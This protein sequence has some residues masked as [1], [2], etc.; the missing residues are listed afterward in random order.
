MRLG[1]GLSSLGGVRAFLRQACSEALSPEQTAD[2]ELLGTEL[3]ANAMRHGAAPIWIEVNRA[4]CTVRIAVCD[5]GSGRPRPSE[6]DC[7]DESGRGLAL[8]RPSPTNGD[9]HSSIAAKR[10]GSRSSPQPESAR[11]PRSSGHPGHRSTRARCRQRWPPR[12]RRRAGARCPVGRWSR[13]PRPR[14]PHPPPHRRRCPSWS[15]A[16]EPNRRGG[17]LPRRRS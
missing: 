15:R 1:P 12:R 7:N 8:V 9:W 2:A 4:G 16:P 13:S 10:C 11:P 14:V 5:R 17:L 6:A 3:V